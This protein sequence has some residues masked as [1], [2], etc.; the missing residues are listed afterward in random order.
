MRRLVYPG[1]QWLSD[2]NNNNK[3]TIAR[4]LR[5]WW[6]HL[7]CKIKSHWRSQC[8]TLIVFVFSTQFTPEWGSKDNTGSPKLRRFYQTSKAGLF[9]WYLLLVWP[10]CTYRG[11]RQSSA[12]PG[13]VSR[14]LPQP[15]PDADGWKG[16]K[17]NRMRRRRSV[18]RVRLATA[19]S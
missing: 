19:K 2:T 1:K 6:W 18:R 7:D 15:E 12:G 16:P 11:I 10:L 17:S 13:S 4:A 9:H 8:F 14:N 5:E 3:S